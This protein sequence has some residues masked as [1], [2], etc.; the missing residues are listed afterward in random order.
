MKV[1]VANIDSVMN[2][3]KKAVETNVNAQFHEKVDERFLELVST[4]PQW[5]GDMA[6]NWQIS[7]STDVEYLRWGGKSDN[8]RQQGTM[9][10][11]G[12]E[13]AVSFAVDRSKLV[14]YTYT[15]VIYFAN[16]TPLTFGVSTVT[17]Q[18]TTHAVRPEN[19]ID[20]RVA[21]ISYL[22]SRFPQ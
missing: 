2:R 22:L 19:L 12:D 15:D 10:Q 13:A 14:Q 21:M 5:S 17:G 9:V 8:Y 16:S 11:M 4:T 18:G 7:T 6:S 1:S 20:G 3:L